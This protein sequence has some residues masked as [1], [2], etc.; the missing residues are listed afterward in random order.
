MPSRHIRG[1]QNAYRAQVALDYIPKAGLS[2]VGNVN[3]LNAGSFA[4]KS[5]EACKLMF[6]K[7]TRQ[8]VML[9]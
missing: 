7:A 4:S 1:D 8:T 9:E 3:E 5:P 2:W 6:G